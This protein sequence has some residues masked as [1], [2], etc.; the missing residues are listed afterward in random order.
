MTLQ[1]D[2]TGSLIHHACGGV[3]RGLLGECCSCIP[4]EYTCTDCASSYTMTVSGVGNSYV[5]GVYTISKFGSN[6]AYCYWRRRIYDTSKM[7][8]EPFDQFHE[9]LFTK[10]GMDW[11]SGRSHPPCVW[12]VA[13][14]VNFQGYSMSDYQVYAYKR[15][16]NFCDVAGSYNVVF[17][18]HGSEHIEEGI[19]V[20]IS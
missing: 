17:A 5:D 10:Y 9:L 13:I 15:R 2:N 16:G 20:V 8:P 6:A 7:P 1:H 4:G 3:P 11:G 19:T 12:R 14:D 18:I